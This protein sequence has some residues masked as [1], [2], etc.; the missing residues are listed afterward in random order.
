MGLP[1]RAGSVL[2]RVLIF[3]GG[4]LIAVRDLVAGRSVAR[5]GLLGTLGW[6]AGRTIHHLVGFLT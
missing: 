5:P 3:G 1:V 4:R 2:G 6:Y